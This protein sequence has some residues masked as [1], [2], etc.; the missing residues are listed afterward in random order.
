MEKKEELRKKFTLKILE[1][2]VKLAK[3][4]P[5]NCIYE[6]GSKEK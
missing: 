5:Y 2:G 4:Q 1:K 6:Y 3:D